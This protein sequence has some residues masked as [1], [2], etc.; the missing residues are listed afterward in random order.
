MHKI[1]HTLITKVLIQDETNTDISSPCPV[2]YNLLSWFR[3]VVHLYSKTSCHAVDMRSLLHYKT[4]YLCLRMRLVLH[5]CTRRPHRDI[6]G[7]TCFAWSVVIF[8]ICI[9]PLLVPYS[10]LWTSPRVTPLA[11]Y[12]TLHCEP[13]PV[14]H[15]LLYTTLCTVNLASCHTACFIP[16]PALWTSPRVT[17]LALYHTLH[18]EPRIMSHRLLYTTPCTVNF[19]SCHN[20]CFIPHSAL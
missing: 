11:L 5:V 17:T 12:H 18:C 16:H 4:G 9:R 1:N 14:S 15:P 6:F 10:A 2:F 8:N 20:P 19:A 7:Q 13:R 3:T